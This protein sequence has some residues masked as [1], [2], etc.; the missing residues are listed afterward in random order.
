M[1]KWVYAVLLFALS[2]D[3][4]AQS[5]WLDSA[6]NAAVKT[7]ESAQRAFIYDDRP[8][9]SFAEPL[10]QQIRQR[11]SEENQRI[12][13]AHEA[14]IQVRLEGEQC[15]KLGIEGKPLSQLLEE[16][17]IEKCQV[18]EIHD[19]CTSAI[20]KTQSFSSNEPLLQASSQDRVTLQQLKAV[21]KGMIHNL[22]SIVEARENCYEFLSKPL[23]DGQSLEC[24]QSLETTLNQN[25]ERV[26]AYCSEK[27]FDSQIEAFI[28]KMR[29]PQGSAHQIYV[30]KEK[31]IK[32]RETEL[33][34]A[35]LLL[36]LTETIQARLSHE[37]ATA[38]SETQLLQK[39]Q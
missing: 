19:S 15:G 8:V 32:V 24:K 39:G 3:V 36:S 4:S 12:H 35:H 20:S 22:N 37:R 7:W 17:F 16:E 9:R 38:S 27:D 25:A 31:Y 33:Q 30:A 10:R 14:A 26:A 1:K 11:V 18:P 6:K 23:V 13:G 34:M 21:H 28:E 29:S 2:L 5:S